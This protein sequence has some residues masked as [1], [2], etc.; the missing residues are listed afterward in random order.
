M[1]SSR[2]A[3]WLKMRLCRTGHLTNVG[4]RTIVLNNPY[5]RQLSPATLNI[6]QEVLPLPG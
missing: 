3:A 5:I 1:R 2:Q 4:G 6:E